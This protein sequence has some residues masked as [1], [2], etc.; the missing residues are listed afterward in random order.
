MSSPSLT[1]YLTFIRDVMGISTAALPDANTAIAMTYN[2]SV[3]LVNPALQSVPNAD[4]TQPSVYAVAVYNLGGDFL[5]NFAQ[6]TAPSMYFTTLRTQLGLNS[7]TAGVINSSS[8]EGT[9]QSMSTPKAFDELTISDLQRLK[10][11]WGRTYLGIAQ[12][13]G[14]L[15]GLT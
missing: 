8:D 7:F 6:D 4:S 1:G 15:W 9:S 3:N 14:S 12:A 11:P 2:L 13:Y 5:V 10:T